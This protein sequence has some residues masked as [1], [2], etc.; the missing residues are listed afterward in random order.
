MEIIR[1]LRPKM[2]Q[3]F[4][5]CAFLHNVKSSDAQFQILHLIILEEIYL[6]FFYNVDFIQEKTP[7]FP[8]PS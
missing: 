3:D 2:L 8:F 6:D 1:K 5:K 7:D 4:P